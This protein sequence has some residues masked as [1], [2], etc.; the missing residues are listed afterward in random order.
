MHL[1]SEHCFPYLH[2]IYQPPRLNWC[3]HSWWE[4][5]RQV[6][7]QG[8]C[9]EASGRHHEQVQSKN[10]PLRPFRTT[11]PSIQYLWAAV[12]TSTSV[13]GDWLMILVS[14]FAAYFAWSNILVSASSWLDIRPATSWWE[15]LVIDTH[16]SLFL[17]PPPMTSCVFSGSPPFTRLHVDLVM[18]SDR[19]PYSLG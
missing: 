18:K 10:D 14:G 2:L 6:M 1:A 3:C 19:F 11:V 12:K 15:S 8:P 13:S 5:G 7:L 9:L 17:N 16:Y 4:H